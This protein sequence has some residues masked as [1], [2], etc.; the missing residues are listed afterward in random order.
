[1]I[2]FI[3]LIKQTIE[4]SLVEKPEGIV[5]AKLISEIRKACPSIDRQ[6]IKEA[7]RT[8]LDDGSLMYVNRL[9][10]TMISTNVN[11]P[12]KIS[13]R[14]WIAPPNTSLHDI[15]SGSV[16]IKISP[17][18]AF[19]N[20]IHPTTKMCLKAM[21]F[22]FMSGA[23]IK[24]M[25]DIGTGTGILAIAASLLGAE[26]CIGTDIDACARSEARANIISNSISKQ[27]IDIID[28][29][30]GLLA[31]QPDL[32][33]ANLRYPT[34]ISMS[35]LIASAVNK[36]G[37]A[38]LSGMRPEEK[39]FVCKKYCKKFELLQ[40]YSESGWNALLLKTNTM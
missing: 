34:L 38:I 9:G 16:L 13:E 36:E 22:I 23:K 37:Y 40:E 24:S 21:D 6:S 7:I 33:T 31:L 20:G 19:G 35:D 28:T 5:I 17:G 2:L 4:K 32:V 14:I 8:L 27:K 39:E 26:K 1:M 18:I 10:Q 25:L 15:S 29:E 30:I 11:R 12:V 3:P